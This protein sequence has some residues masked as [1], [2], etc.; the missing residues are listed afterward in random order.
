M[1]LLDSHGRSTA[2]PGRGL[3]DW[4]P[5]PRGTREVLARV[6]APNGDVV[7]ETL[8]DVVPFFGA[9][10]DPPLVELFD[11]RGRGPSPRR[12]QGVVGVL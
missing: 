10:R 5:D 3:A 6:L 1:A 7:V 11:A 8:G 9:D 12:L 4:M 2:A